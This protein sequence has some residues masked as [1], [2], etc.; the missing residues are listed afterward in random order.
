[1]ERYFTPVQ[2]PTF[3]PE[4]AAKPLT[5]A[6]MTAHQKRV[7]QANRLRSFQADLRGLPDKPVVFG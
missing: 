4:D 2:D 5:L 6:D 3:T 7:E 1:M